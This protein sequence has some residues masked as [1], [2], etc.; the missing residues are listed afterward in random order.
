MNEEFKTKEIVSELVPHKGKMFLLNRVQSYSL[1]T[2]SI[3]T[4]IDITR[5]DLFYEEDLGGVPAW[6]A[7]EYMA[8]SISALSGIYGRSR[9]E[10]PKVG[11]IMSVN[12][13]KANVPVFKVGETVVVTVRQTIRMDMA[14]TFDG[15]AKVGE[16]LAVS[17]TLNTVEVEDPK[18]ALG[19]N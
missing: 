3:T 19:L 6:V 18:M 9:G 11:F 10:K 15:T 16:T 17:A 2:I 14:V 4:E 7:F 8:Q 13:F 5:E 1:E 12:S